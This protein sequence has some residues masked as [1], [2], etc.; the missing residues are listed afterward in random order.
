LLTLCC[1]SKSRPGKAGKAG[2]QASKAADAKTSGDDER[3]SEDDS[4]A[5]DEDFLV[6]AALCAQ[7]VETIHDWCK[8]QL[9]QAAAFRHV[10]QWLAA[11]TGQAQGRSRQ[12]RASEFQ[13]RA[14]AQRVPALQPRRPLEDLPQI[15]LN[16]YIVSTLPWQGSDWE[17]A[18]SSSD[19]DDDELGHGGGEG[20]AE[21]AELEGLRREAANDSPQQRGSSRRKRGADTAQQAKHIQ[22]RFCICMRLRSF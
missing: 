11:R 4:E 9:G 19:D 21:N 5:D 22:K 12:K 13:R 7:A 6:C 18:L 10:Y 16:C 14:T 17:L 15:H 20:N 1:R 8:T 2:R 3:D